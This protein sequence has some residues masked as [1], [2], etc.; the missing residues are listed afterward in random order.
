MPF[1]EETSRFEA[2]NDKEKDRY[3]RVKVPKQTEQSNSWA[4]K[5]FREWQKDYRI[6][7]PNSGFRGDVLEKVHCQELDEVLST[8]VVETWK[9]NGD[10]YPP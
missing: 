7:N 1:L 10:K 6:G 9:E 8:F 4:L 5:N 2:L 3:S